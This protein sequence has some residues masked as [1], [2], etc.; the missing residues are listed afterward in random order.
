MEYYT[1][2]AKKSTFSGTLLV[3]DKKLKDP[4]SGAKAF[5]NFFIT[6]LENTTFIKQRKEM[7]SQF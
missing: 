4:S 7:L 6:I 5:S 3:N 2:S 1:E